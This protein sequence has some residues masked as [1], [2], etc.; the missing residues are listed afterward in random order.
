MNIIWVFI[1]Y[2]IQCIKDENALLLYLFLIV[3]YTLI[4]KLMGCWGVGMFWLR[5]NKLNS[6]SIGHNDD[7][8]EGIK[9]HFNARIK[10]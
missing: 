4:F 9:Q 5:L 1:T 2:F 8:L 3:I 6:F 7:F 10:R